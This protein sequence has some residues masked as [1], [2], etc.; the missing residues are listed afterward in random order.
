LTTIHS[1]LE[2]FREAATSNRDL[3]D[4]FERLVATYLTVDPLY[5]DKYSDVWLWTEWPGR[6]NQPDTGID[7]VAKERYTGEYCAIQCKFYLPSHN[8]QKE[9]IDS[10]FTASGKKPF[11]SRIIVSTTDRWSNNADVRVL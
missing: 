11:T 1:I 7:L 8:L 10:F 4:K 5:Q 9:D 2:E 3:G 6:G